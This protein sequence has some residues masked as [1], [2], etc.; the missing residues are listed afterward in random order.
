M[1]A[2]RGGKGGVG[3]GQKDAASS[4]GSPGRPTDARGYG[5]GLDPC[6][7]TLVTFEGVG[8][9]QVDDEAG[10]LVAFYMQP[11]RAAFHF[12]LPA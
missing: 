2:A 4:Q 12:L 9:C 5:I 1:R 8:L 6:A 3:G 11:H 7:L 10:L